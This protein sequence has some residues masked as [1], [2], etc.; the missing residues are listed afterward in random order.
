MRV[1]SMVAAV[2]F[3]LAACGGE[4]KA[5]NT[6][7]AATDSAAAT[8]PAAAA[9]ATG[10]THD[11]DMTM[12]DGQPRFVPETLTVKPGDAV[13]FVNKEGGPHNIQFWSD[14]LPAGGAAAISIDKQLAPME[15]EMMVDQGATFTVTFAANAPTGSYGFTCVPHGAMGMHGKITVQ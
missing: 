10:T 5:D 9:P 13:R 15:S 7:A 4:K 3:V 2:A 12:V 14:S 8:A 6:P 1:T 11:V